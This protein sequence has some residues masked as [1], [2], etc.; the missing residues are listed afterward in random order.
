ML[1]QSFFAVEDSAMSFTEVTTAPFLS[2]EDREVAKSTVAAIVRSENLRLE[3]NGST[4]PLPHDAVAKIVNMLH[5]MADGQS[6]EIVPA[7]HELTVRQARIFLRMS[8]RHLS[9]LLDAGEIKSRM[10][11]G[12]RM[13]SRDS[14]LEFEQERERLAAGLDDIVRESQEMGLYDD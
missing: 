3:A 4:Y 10:V 11:D 13:I 5:L 7:L 1:F 9:D 2:E 14:L 8:E 6:V 12:E